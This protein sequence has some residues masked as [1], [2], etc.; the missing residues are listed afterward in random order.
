[1]TKRIIVI[2]S[3][4]AGLWSALSAMRLIEL[5]GGEKADIEVTVVAPEPFLNLRPRFYEANSASMN[6]PL[7]D[8]FHVAGIQFVQGIVDTIRSKEHEIE[9]VDQ[10]GQRSTLNYDRLILATGSHLMRPDI[11]GLRKHA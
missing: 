4:F 9:V 10:I 3:G 6:T 5:N 1:M 11:P 8:I 2:G 7:S